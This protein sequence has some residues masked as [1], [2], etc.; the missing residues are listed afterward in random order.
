MS[1]DQLLH[2]YN[3]A[4][5]RFG[6]SRDGAYKELQ[7]ARYALATR[8]TAMLNALKEIKNSFNTNRVSY[9]IASDALK[10]IGE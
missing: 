5:T 4:V 6:E 8:D 7:A 1:F 10:K 2:N 3:V 9:D